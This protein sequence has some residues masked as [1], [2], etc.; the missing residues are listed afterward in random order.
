MSGDVPEI[1]DGN[2]ESA[3]EADQSICSI[4]KECDRVN[5]TFIGDLNVNT[6]DVGVQRISNRGKT[7]DVLS[8]GIK[9]S[10]SPVGEHSLITS[11]RLDRDQLKEI[12]DRAK[13]VGLV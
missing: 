13:T 3:S 4:R 10:S 7:D 12:F 2:Q 1:R 11:I 9:G 6:L 5:V 8:L